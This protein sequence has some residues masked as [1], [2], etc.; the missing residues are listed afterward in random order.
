MDRRREANPVLLLPGAVAEAAGL[1]YG[2]RFKEELHKSP[3]FASPVLGA[4]R[5][6][7]PP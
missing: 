3:T 1:A 6:P 2:N 4:Q 5:P 7:R